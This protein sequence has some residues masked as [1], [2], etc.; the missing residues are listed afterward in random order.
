MRGRCELVVNGSGADGRPKR[1]AGHGAV[2]LAVGDDEALMAT[3]SIHEKQVPVRVVRISH[4][5]DVYG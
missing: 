4:R 5:A 3:H 2:S 1:P